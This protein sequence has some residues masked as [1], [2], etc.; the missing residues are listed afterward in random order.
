M[1]DEVAFLFLWDSP[2]AM[3]DSHVRVAADDLDRV[4]WSS[5]SSPRKFLHQASIDPQSEEA[6]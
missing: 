5:L 6:P 3:G 2:M 4:M 1:Q